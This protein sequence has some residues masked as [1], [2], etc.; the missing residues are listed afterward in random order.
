M[1]ATK[2]D[3]SMAVIAVY[4]VKGGV[5]KTTIAANLAWFSA[6]VSCRRTLLW[7]LDASGG[8]GFLFGIDPK[9][10]AAAERVFSREAEPVS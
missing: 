4:S 6:V 10:K 9:R 1:Q 3:A 8:A 7:D 2:G 5:G